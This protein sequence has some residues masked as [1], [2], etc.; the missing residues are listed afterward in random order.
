MSIVHGTETFTS[1]G[2]FDI[3]E[4]G[5]VVTW[6]CNRGFYTKNATN[7]ICHQGE[8]NITRPTCLCKL[9]ELIKLWNI[10]FVLFLR[11]LRTFSGIITLCSFFVECFYTCDVHITLLNNPRILMNFVR[12]SSVL[13]NALFLPDQYDGIRQKQKL[14]RF[15]YAFGVIFCI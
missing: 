6:T 9:C 8:W 11:P 3:R 10:F 7:A 1:S 12:A 14:F 2:N 15:P 4:E 5:S 13:S